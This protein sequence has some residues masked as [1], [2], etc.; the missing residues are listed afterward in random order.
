MVNYD[1]ALL[2]WRVDDGGDEDGFGLVEGWQDGVGRLH[3]GRVDDD[4]NLIDGG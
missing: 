4:G 1:L 3:V 2:L